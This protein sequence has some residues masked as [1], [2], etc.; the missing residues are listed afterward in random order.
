M[1]VCGGS[2]ASSAQYPGPS[3][4]PCRPVHAQIRTGVYSY[5][6]RS[7]LARSALL[8]CTDGTRRCMYI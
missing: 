5:V 1:V 2:R 3:A 4:A 8:E 7:T 6:V